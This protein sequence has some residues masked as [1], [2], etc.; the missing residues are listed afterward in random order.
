MMV[1]TCRGKHPGRSGVVDELQRRELAA[2]AA[3]DRERLQ[4]YLTTKEVAELLRTSPETMRYWAWQGKGPK[5]FKAGRK[6]LYAA[7]DIEAWL[8]DARNGAA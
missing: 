1:P 2:A 8:A 6:R 7:E 3:R 5:S 4:R